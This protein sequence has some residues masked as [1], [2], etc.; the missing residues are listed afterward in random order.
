MI[1]DF[2]ADCEDAHRELGGGDFG[3]SVPRD[4]SGRSGRAMPQILCLE[5]DPTAATELFNLLQ[6]LGYQASVFSVS[7]R[8]QRS[9][10]GCYSSYLITVLRMSCV[11]QVMPVADGQGAL[12]RHLCGGDDLP[13][14]ILIAVA[15]ADTSG[16]EVA[17]QRSVAVRHRHHLSNTGHS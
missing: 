9:S 7:F 2:I 16:I 3:G 14:L 13:D 11:T 10:R 5:S 15:L 12:A 1:E 6:P 8:R 4:S 17:R